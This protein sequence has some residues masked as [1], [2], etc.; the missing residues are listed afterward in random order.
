MVLCSNAMEHVVPFMMENMLKYN[1][2]D[3]GV[4]V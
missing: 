1:K 2:E 4:K 3:W